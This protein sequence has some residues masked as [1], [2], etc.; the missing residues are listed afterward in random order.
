MFKLRNPDSQD[1]E[2]QSFLT[3][4]KKNSITIF[5]N[6]LMIKSLHSSN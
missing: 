6:E 2:N 1:T 4:D 5:T 3:T